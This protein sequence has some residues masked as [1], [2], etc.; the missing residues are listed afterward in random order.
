[1]DSGKSLGDK[2][3][4]LASKI[5]TWPDEPLRI[6]DEHVDVLLLW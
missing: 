6:G 3:E 5:G 2:I 1:M 4:V